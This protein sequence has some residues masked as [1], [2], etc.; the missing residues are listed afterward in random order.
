MGVVADKFTEVHNR[1]VWLFAHGMSAPRAQDE[2]DRFGIFETFDN[3]SHEGNLF[4][5]PYLMDFL[6]N[7][8]VRRL[9]LF[10]CHQGKYLESWYHMP[11]HDDVRP[12]RFVTGFDSSAN[13]SSAPTAL[14]SYF[15][16]PQNFKLDK[17]F[18]LIA[19]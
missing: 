11:M 17:K 15:A 9:F 12:V 8:K 10:A 19:A 4:F 18:S 6:G 5:T 16:N 14:T 1:D 7:L 13:R 2:M 3:N